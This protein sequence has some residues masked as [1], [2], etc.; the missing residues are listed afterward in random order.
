MSNVQRQREAL[1]ARLRELRAAA[2]MSGKWL[3]EALGWQPAKV[4]RIEHGKRTPTADDVRA[5]TEAT[6]SADEAAALLA[7]LA[8]LDTLYSAWRRSLSSGA[9]RKQREWQARQA[10]TREL[11]V[12]ECNVVPGL[13]QTAEYARCRLLDGVRMHGAPTDVDEAV[14]VRMGR[15]EALYR[16]G[17][18]FHLVITEAVLYYRTAPVSVLLAQLDRLVAATAVPSLRFGVLPFDTPWPVDVEHG[19]WIFDDQAVLVEMI[20]AELT[21]TQT[22]EVALHLA[23][24]GRLA[25]AAVY[26]ADARKLINRALTRLAT[27]TRTDKAATESARRG[28][29]AESGAATS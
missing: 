4:S 26:G 21:L 24:F 1:G 7:D 25:D 17:K 19:F 23:V 3:A 6:G 20:A 28:T 9:A 11:R 10:A 29:C 2:G 16:P 8:A 5:W 12:F 14:A 27:A 22:D 13:L 15:Q 18:R